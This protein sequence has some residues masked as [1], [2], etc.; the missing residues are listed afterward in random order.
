MTGPYPPYTL[1]QGLHVTGVSVDT[2]AAIMQMTDTPFN[3]KSIRLVQWK[4]AVATTMAMPNC[5]MLNVPRTP[6]VEQ[7]FQ[8]VG[9]LDFPEFGLIGKAGRDFGIHSIA[10]ASQYTIGAVRGQD[11]A[12]EL[13]A[14]GL[15]PSALKTDTLYVQPLRGLQSGTLDLVAFPLENVTYLMRK[16]GLE[17]SDYQVAFVYKK[18]PLYIALSKGVDPMFVK[19]L[20]DALAMYKS[21]MADGYSV[22][23]KTMARYLPYGTVE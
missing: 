20:N 7:K 14:Q 19:K 10:D 9:P 12:K 6:D 1:A 11:A 3:K 21:P 8:W 22:F 2:M 13:L 15:K 5:A 17:K 23:D 16:M 18:I 4:K